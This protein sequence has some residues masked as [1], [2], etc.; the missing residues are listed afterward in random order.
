MHRADAI[1]L[2]AWQI[3]LVIL[4]NLLNLVPL[5]NLA[6]LVMH[7]EYLVILANQVIQVNLMNLV[8]PHAHV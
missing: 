4:G 1:I 3:H 5:V 8:N 2:G 7:C 6:Y